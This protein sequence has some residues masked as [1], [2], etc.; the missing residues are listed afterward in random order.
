MEQVKSI[1]D[2]LKEFA[3]TQRISIREF[4]RKCGLGNSFVNH[5]GQSLGVD[6]LENILQV[7]PTL[8]KDWI[9]YGSGEMILNEVAEDMKADFQ[10]NFNKVCSLI[11]KKDEQIDRLLDLLEVQ[12]D[13]V[14]KD[15]VKN[16]G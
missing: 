9:L 6:K 12:K 7:F 13:E 2:R 3:K 16:A 5:I 4:E 8:N 10:S 11:Q 1:S 14:K 15:S